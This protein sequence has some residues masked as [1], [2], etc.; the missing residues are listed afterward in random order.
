MSNN[1]IKFLLLEYFVFMLCS[2]YERNWPISLYWLGAI[3]LNAGVLC[4]MK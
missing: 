1:L 2:I 4:G 3:I